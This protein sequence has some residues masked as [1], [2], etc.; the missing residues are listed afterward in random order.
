MLFTAA[1]RGIQIYWCSVMSEI[2]SIGLQ[3]EAWGPRFWLIL[4]SLAERSGSQS[5][6]VLQNDE[7]DAWIILLKSQA[8][9]M[10]CPLCKTHY[11]EYWTSHKPDKVRSLQGLE[12]RSFLRTW[13]WNAHDRVNKMAEKESPPIESL[14]TLYPQKSLDKPLKELTTMFQQALAAQQLKPEDINRWKSVIQRL[15]LLIGT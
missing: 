8:F 7:A 6:M 12:R 2:K 1:A 4:H 5:N 13:V 15:R 3:R 11:L 10:P 14:P 9:V